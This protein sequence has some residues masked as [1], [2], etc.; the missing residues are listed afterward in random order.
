M[1]E[2]K[3]AVKDAAANDLER[4]GL[5]LAAW[6]EKWFPDAWVFALSGIVFVFCFGIIIGETPTKLV[7]EGGKSFWILIPFTMQMALIIIGGYVVATTPAVYWVIKKVAAI[8]NSRQ[9]RAKQKI[10]TQHF[11]PQFVDQRHFG[12]KPVPAN[13]KSV[14]FVIYCAR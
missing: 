7:V 6:S 4:F 10:F 14:A 11:S 8:M 3:A 12:K 9:T 2:K 5:G 1:P 13:I